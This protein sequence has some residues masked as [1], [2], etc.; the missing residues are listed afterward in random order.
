MNSC[1]I[2]AGE[3]S[4]QSCDHQTAVL[5]G[6]RQG[7]RHERTA[8]VGHVVG[9]FG[10]EQSVAKAVTDEP[11]HHLQRPR[12]VSH[13]RFQTAVPE[14]RQK[15][16]AARIEVEQHQRLRCQGL[17][18]QRRGVRQGVA[19]GQKH[20]G[21]EIREVFRV[22]VVAQIEVVEQRQFDFIAP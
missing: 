21:D 17:Q 14:Q 16:V 12:A 1:A 11:A 2:G 3:S 18:R 6:I 19:L 4:G 7:P 10:G 20:V 13:T 8:V 22:D 5:D 9:G 15:I